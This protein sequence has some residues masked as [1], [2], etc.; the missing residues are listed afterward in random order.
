MDKMSQSLWKIYFGVHPSLVPDIIAWYM[1]AEDL[2]RDIQL[3]IESDTQRQS[4][5][6]TATPTDTANHSNSI[7]HILPISSVE[8]TPP[9]RQHEGL[10]PVTRHRHRRPTI[11]TG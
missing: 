5:V 9:R 8:H 6:E 3:L 11:T 10:S 7:P 4:E 2:E 1:D